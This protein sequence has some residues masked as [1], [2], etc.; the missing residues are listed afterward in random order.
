MW[1]F[2]F[3]K[4]DLPHE[5]IHQLMEPNKVENIICK[6]ESI[7]NKRQKKKGHVRFAISSNKQVFPGEKDDEDE[8]MAIKRI[9]DGEEKKTN[10]T[11]VKVV[12][13][14]QD[15][16]RL[17][18]KCKDGSILGFR[19]VAEEIVQIPIN[20]VCVVSNDVRAALNTIQEEA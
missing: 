6:D 20:R 13:M 7:K 8:S 12:M 9:G 1:S 10:I 16:D 3:C 18:S 19:E 4:R 17:L 11:R 2:S 15:A 14:K 5:A